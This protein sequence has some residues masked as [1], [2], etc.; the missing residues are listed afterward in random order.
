MRKIE[1]F[2]ACIAAAIALVLAFAFAACSPT[3]K[4][5]PGGGDDPAGP[6]TEGDVCTDIVITQ[7]PV[8]LTY[9]DGERF[10][11]A[12][13]LFDA[14]YENGYDGDTDLDASDLDGWSPAGA[15]DDSV[16][17]ITLLFDGVQKRIDITVTPKTLLGMQITRE[18]DTKSYSV[19]DK[20]D[21]SGLTVS[22]SYEEGDVPVESRYKVTDKDGNEYKNGTVLTVPSLD[23]EL[24]VSVTAGEVT[25]SDTFSISVYAGFSLQAEDYWSKSGGA[26]RPTEKSYTVLSENGGEPRQYEGWLVMNDCTFTGTG[27]IG[28]VTAGV[29]IEFYIYSEVAIENAELVLVA[30]A[31]LC[32][33]A[34][35]KMD[36]MQFNEFCRVYLGAEGEEQE[37]Y[38]DD[39]VIIEGK[40][41]PSVESG[42]SQWT[43]WA[44]VP[45]GRF[46]IKPGYNRIVIDCV[47]GII[48]S[49][50]SA[51][52]PN[53]DRL[54]I[55]MTEGEKQG[56]FVQS[57]TVKSYP[58]KT[59][60]LAGEIF[61]A[62]GIL[63]DVTYRNGYDGDVN[64]G[65][66]DIKLVT[67]R[68]L[69]A[70]DK[71]VTLK[72]KNYEI[73]VD[74][75]VTERVLESM[76]ITAFPSVT[77]YFAGTP[78]DFKGLTVKATYADG[79]VDNNAT[80]YTVTDASGKVYT[81]GT[82]LSAG[83][84]ENITFTVT[85]TSG[86]VTKSDTFVLTV[87]PGI[88]IQ[89]EDITS[90]ERKSYVEYEG[91][92]AIGSDGD[93]GADKTGKYYVKGYGVGTKMI[94][95][96]Y[97]PQAVENAMVFMR[98]ASCEDIGGRMGD[99]QFNG[100]FKLYFGE[101]NTEIPV[102][103]ATVITGKPYGD[104]AWFQWVSVHIAT[105]DLVEGYNVLT[106]ECYST[107]TYRW[108]P[109][110]DKI[111]V[112]TAG[113]VATGV[114]IVSQPTKTEY[115]DGEAFD[116]AG[117]TFTAT[118]RNGY[119]SGEV[120]T[121]ESVTVVTQTL[122][123]GD[124]TATLSY[125][126]F[127]FTVSVTV[128]ERKVESVEVTPPTKT[129]YESG[130]EL[131]FA[132]LVV[133]ATYEGGV[134]VDNVT[135]YAVKDASGKTYKHGDVIVS[136]E[137]GTVDITLTVE[138]A[139]GGTT[140]T[141]TFTVTVT[142]P[143]VIT[144]GDIVTNIEITT[145]PKTEYFEGETFDI[146]GL[147]FAVT[148]QNGYDGDTALTAD[149]AE[150]KTSAPLNVGDTA[151]TVIYKGY[152]Y[153]FDIIVTVSERKTVSVEAVNAIASYPNGGVF[154]FT[155]LAVKATY[156]GGL[157]NENENN[158]VLKDGDGNVFGTGSTVTK[159]TTFTVEVT[160]GGVT[161]TASFAVTVYD[162]GA[163]I[164][165]KDEAV[166]DKQSYVK[167]V[168]TSIWDNGEND[169]KDYA[170][171]FYVG[172]K[173]EYYIY[174]DVAVKNVKLFWRIASAL[175]NEPEGKMD[176][177]QFNKMFKVYAG[178]TE[179]AVSDD[180]VITGKP[181]GSS[182]WFNWVNIQIATVDFEAGYNKVVVEFYND[183]YSGST[184]NVDRLEI[185][186]G[187]A[188]TLP[189]ETDVPSQ[190]TETAITK[191][192]I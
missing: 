4:P 76:E 86:G 190:Q 184:P 33:N 162:K 64:L 188:E 107:A 129:E 23:F 42:G 127:E 56:D 95:R 53:I 154:D 63:F 45:F 81:N 128:T 187:E 5:N 58:S 3:V 21:L 19:G 34:E 50:G 169:C 113:D 38:I 167:H 164:R 144:R 85:M 143:I 191:E 24:T 7:M 94:Y 148:Y 161:K 37:I 160:S 83:D 132:G 54:D 163:T 90:G 186:F 32:N 71:T 175:Y 158:Y 102:G 68:P 146:T 119:V 141:A 65:A 13:L 69:K 31:T 138:V 93:I 137:D 168:G 47:K 170:R 116:P 55:R 14:V 82:L 103:D 149:S 60:Y 153:E 72:Y 135:D 97:S 101:N 12:G 80:G 182:P 121:A 166:V 48:D 180:V 28:N 123:A 109:N 173:I 181:F 174:S 100:I 159:D 87:V 74:V 40:P 157:V 131:D 124:A 36:D 77:D 57:V 134:T 150:L 155:A 35:G 62:T 73:T 1:K 165:M 130:D 177:M 91:S 25:F 122:A 171:G 133:S 11:P 46:D 105:V 41:Y 52:M 30:A 79:F 156:E 111:E 104:A 136:T 44:D 84:G 8:K 106:V 178:E 22:A 75:T 179:L 89:A 189:E 110:I 99:V 120:V 66:D 152:N 67:D 51:R 59:E 43:N 15:L 49:T 27:Y 61:D 139:S 108:F 117:L 147:V 125:K 151:V 92:Y 118:Y 185:E 88:S 183:G 10:N 98:A 176:D 2:I 39:D 17:Q 29:K 112:L 70:S 78:V 140:S 115:L 20:L 16:K 192:L 96:I 18:P 145:M 6:V 142:K 114:N 26:P 9:N 172:V 126:G